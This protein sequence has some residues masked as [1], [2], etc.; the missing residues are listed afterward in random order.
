MTMASTGQPWELQSAMALVKT[1]TN[2][3]LKSLLKS[4][5]LPVSGVKVTLQMRIIGRSSCLLIVSAFLAPVPA[6]IVNQSSSA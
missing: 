6:R 3:Q 2:S 1:L 5:S 4:E